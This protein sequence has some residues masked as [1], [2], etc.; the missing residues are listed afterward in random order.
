MTFAMMLA[1]LTGVMLGG[2]FFSFSTFVMRGLGDAPPE[3]GMVAMQEINKRVYGS[4][5]LAVFT[6]FGFASIG[7]LIWG[8]WAGNIWSVAGASLYLLGLIAMTMFVHVPMNKRLDRG[9]A[10]LGYWPDYHARWTRLN[11]IRSFSCF[12]SAGAFLMAGLS[13]AGI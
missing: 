13:Y 6:G 3:A 7:L 12:A 8:V 5:F 9:R 2:I 10:A 11:H 1:A 4:E